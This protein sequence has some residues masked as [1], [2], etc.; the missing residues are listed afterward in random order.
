MFVCLTSVS[1]RKRIEYRTKSH[2]EPRLCWELRLHG[3]APKFNLRPTRVALLSTQR[4][5]E[6]SIKYCVRPPLVHTS[7]QASASARMTLMISLEQVPSSTNRS[8]SLSGRSNLHQVI[9]LKGSTLP[10]PF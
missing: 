2:G 10:I 1:V 6:T 5:K 3:Q 8:Y 7:W 9:A 4:N